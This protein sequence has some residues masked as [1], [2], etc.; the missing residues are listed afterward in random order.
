LGKDLL[1]H[2]RLELGD[3]VFQTMVGRSQQG[4]SLVELMVVVAII[5]I[6]ASIAMKRFDDVEEMTM[7]PKF[8]DQAAAEAF[9]QKAYVCILGV[10]G[11]STGQSN[12]VPSLDFGSDGI[13]GINDANQ[14]RSGYQCTAS[15][16]TIKI[17]RRAAVDAASGVAMMVEE[18]EYGAKWEDRTT[19]T[20]AD[21]PSACDMNSDGGFTRADLLWLR[22]ALFYHYRY[23]CKRP[24]RLLNNDLPTIRAWIKT[25]LTPS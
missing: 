6:L 24:D 10:T 12:Y 17:I 7:T 5:G 4:F 1:L 11:S 14:I 20:S 15:T 21:A 9:A 22:S 8:R 23:T 16:D 25:Y 18:D 13:I 3:G 2:S 19:S